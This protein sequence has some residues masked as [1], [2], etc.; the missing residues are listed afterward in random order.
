[1]S[2]NESLGYVREKSRE[3]SN[4][5]FA[6]GMAGSLA[7]TSAIGAL[8]TKEYGLFFG[9]AMGAAGTYQLWEE[10]VTALSEH[11]DELARLYASLREYAP[12]E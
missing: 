6:A 5:A 9:T 1:M 12:T 8:I 10:S 11:N 2:K 7:V 4:Y 3:A